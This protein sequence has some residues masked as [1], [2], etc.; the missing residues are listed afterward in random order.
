MKVQTFLC[1][2]IFALLLQLTGS[3][4]ALAHSALLGSTPPQDAMLESAPRTVTLEFNEPVEPLSILVFMP[5]SGR[6]DLSDKVEKGSTLVVPLGDNLSAGTYVVSWRVASDDGHPVAGSQVFSIGTMTTPSQEALRLSDPTVQAMVVVAK[7][8][9]YIC[10]FGGVGMALF[11]ALLAPLPKSLQGPAIGLPLVG[12]LAAGSSIGL[13]GLDALG[14]TLGA[15]FDSRAWQTAFATSYGTST[16]FFV[17]ALLLAAVALTHGGWLARIVAVLAAVALGWGLSASGHASAAQPQ[18]LTRP[19]VFLHGVALA[20]WLGALAPLAVYLRSSD[21]A[22]KLALDRF[23]RFIPWAV[24]PLL[25]SGG[26]LFAIQ[27][28]LPNRQWLSSYGLVMLTKLGLLTLLF[29][30]ALL[31]RLRLTTPALAGEPRATARLGLSV[32]GEIVIAIIILGLVASLRFTPPP[33]VLSQIYPDPASAHLEAD[34]YT[35]DV[36]V[37]PGRAGLV[38]VDISLFTKGAAADAQALTASFSQPELGIEPLTRTA[39]NLG[40]NHWRVE[41]LLLPVH[42]NWNLTL[43]ARVSRFSQVRLSG[44][45]AIE[46]VEH[47]TRPPVVVASVGPIQIA[48]PFSR[49]T[50]PGAPVGGAY[51]IIFN[52]G[53]KEDAITSATTPVAGRVTPHDMQVDSDVMRMRELAEGIVIPAGQAVRLEPG[54]LHLM[55]ETLNAPL[56]EGTTVPLTLTFRNGGTVTIDLPVLGIAA[57]GSDDHAGHGG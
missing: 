57:D 23:S 36:V 53:D 2:L 5:D 26:V 20:F 15:F 48:D 29:A 42:G 45:V 46:N 50:L 49:S 27:M 9:L 4:P 24:V 21:A 14:L 32:R 40:N 33:R 37:D 38:S 55:L 8:V 47:S 6:T 34:G 12:L 41:G 25:L 17:F 54:G 7:A 56:V 31:N 16:I 39:E 52:T 3:V 35:A 30:L 43:D 11:A 28:G 51:F 19:A 18:W 13:Q 1:G 22:S 44:S 10:L